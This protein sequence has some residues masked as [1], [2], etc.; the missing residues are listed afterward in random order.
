MPTKNQCCFW[1][2]RKEKEDTYMSESLL[3]GIIPVSV[4]L[5][6]RNSTRFANLPSSEGITP[7]NRFPW[8]SLGH[9]RVDELWNWRNAN[10][11]INWSQRLLLKYIFFIFVMSPISL[12]IGPVSWLVPRM[13]SVRFFSMLISF[14]IEP[15]SIFSSSL[16]QMVC[17]DYH[18]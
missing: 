14:G 7:F 6:N 1:R 16:L 13:S 17:Q 2:L 11:G 10:K 4:L 3:A 9:K 12:G 18:L 5:L 8:R 15:M